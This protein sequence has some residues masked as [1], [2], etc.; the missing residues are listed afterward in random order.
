MIEIFD[1]NGDGQISREEWMDGWVK[2]GK[3]LPDFEV[4]DQNHRSFSSIILR[5]PWCIKMENTRG[6]AESIGNGLGSNTSYN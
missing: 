3:R 6:R 2:E 4:C 5:T 1:K